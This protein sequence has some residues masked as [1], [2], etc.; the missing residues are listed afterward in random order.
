MGLRAPVTAPPGDT[1]KPGDRVEVT[2]EALAFGGE[3]VAHAPDGRVV[4]VPYLAPG[5]RAAVWIDEIKPAFARGRLDEVLGPSPDRVTP[6]CGV[7]GTCGGCQWQ[8]VSLAAQRAAKE[9][10]VRRMLEG[11]V[12]DPAVIRAIVGVDDGLAYRNRLVMPVRAG[13]TGLRAGFFR[14]DSHVIVETT[15]CPVQRSA[16]MDAANDA[17]ALARLTHVTGYNERLHRG[18]L[19]HLVVREA[20]GTGEVGVVLVTTSRMFPEGEAIATDLMRRVP[21]VKGVLHNVNPDRTNVVFGPELRTLGGSE[22]L[23]ERIGGMEIEAS[24]LSFFQANHA[25]TER[26]LEHV[27]DWTRD[28]TGGLLDL[29]CGVGILGLAAARAGH[30]RWLAGVESAEGAV[31]D[32]RRNAAAV[33]PALPAHWIAAPVETGIAALPADCRDPGTVILD[34]P[35]KGLSPAAL[36]ALIALRPRRIVYVSCDP[37]TLAR[38]LKALVEAGWNVREAVPFDMFPHTYH[39]EVAVRLA[40]E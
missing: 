4:F 37:A 31:A 26:L 40:L 27:V 3:T 33:V 10:I 9:R 24:I 18:S 34:P 39:V 35:R 6:P 22:T 20:S 36:A 23:R 16:I 14:G 12:T 32:A 17:L 11:V 29:Y 15:S 5:D 8:H 30:P 2:G 21:A 7:F 13:K 28:E 38:D 19:R 25:V 1:L